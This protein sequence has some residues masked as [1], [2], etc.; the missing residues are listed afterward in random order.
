MKTAPIAMQTEMAVSADL[1][2]L[3][4]LAPKSVQRLVEIFFRYDFANNNG[5]TD[6][7]KVYCFVN[8][9]SSTS[10]TVV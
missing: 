8:N 9:G 5:S 7:E 2:G 3:A 1:A 4:Q 10:F 6:F